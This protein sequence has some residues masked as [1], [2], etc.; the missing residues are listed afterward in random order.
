MNRFSLSTCAI[1]L[2]GLYSAAWG[3]PGHGPEDALAHNLVHLGWAL[4]VLA[5]LV[6]TVWQRMRARTGAN[7][8]DR[9]R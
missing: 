7:A 8:K 3:H 9:E 5:V 6:L 4:P 2:I 1:A